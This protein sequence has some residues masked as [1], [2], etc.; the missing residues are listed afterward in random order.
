MYNLYVVHI[1]IPEK[2]RINILIKD[3]DKQ[4]ILIK[5]GSTDIYFIVDIFFELFCLMIYIYFSMV[6]RNL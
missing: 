2:R 5:K 6:W 4:K 3:E 1:K